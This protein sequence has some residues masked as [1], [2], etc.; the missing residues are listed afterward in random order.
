MNIIKSDLVSSEYDVLWQ[1][2]GQIVKNATPKPVMVLINTYP[3]GSPDETQLL[4]MLE[5]SKLSPEQYNIVQI[6][7]NTPVA[8]HKLRDQLDPKVVF[9]IGILPAQ[10]GISS[11]FKLNA[12][13]H[14]ND[15]IWLATLSL[16]E[17]EQFPDVKKQLWTNG[18][19]PIFVDKVF[20]E[21]A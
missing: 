1:D 18:M 10:L 12:P 17:L 4:K 7:K 8:W 11:L 13:N 5:V 2:I 19:K 14:F 6:E 9:L 3:P 15:R 20:S 16:G 21:F